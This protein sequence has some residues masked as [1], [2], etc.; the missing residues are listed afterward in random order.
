MGVAFGSASHFS[1]AQRAQGEAAWKKLEQ[2][3]KALRGDQTDA[4]L[5]MRSAQHTNVDT[6]PGKPTS[7]EAMNSHVEKV[8]SATEQI[9]RTG[10][11]SQVIHVAD[12][13]ALAGC[14]GLTIITTDEEEEATA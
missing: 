4:I 13:T 1:K 2:W 5:V 11:P 3:G 12:E 6:L 9:L 7:P 8:K 10:D 14:R